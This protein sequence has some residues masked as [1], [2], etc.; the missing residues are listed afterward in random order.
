MAEEVRNIYA[1]G[2]DERDFKDSPSPTLLPSNRPRDSAVCGALD[3][4][5]KKRLIIVEA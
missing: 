5:G 4:P 2:R 1:F 3:L